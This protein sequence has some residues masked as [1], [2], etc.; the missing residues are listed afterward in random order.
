MSI[1]RRFFSSTASS[2]STKLNPIDFPQY[3]SIDAIDN[4]TIAR[5]GVRN[6]FQTGVDDSDRQLARAGDLRRRQLR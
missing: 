2:H 5:I 4:W 1:R 3:T 6:R